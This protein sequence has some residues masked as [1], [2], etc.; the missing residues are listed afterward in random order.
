MPGTVSLFG[1]PKVEVEQRMIVVAARV[2]GRPCGRVAFDLENGSQNGIAYLVVQR[3]SRVP[4]LRH[5]WHG[6]L[7]R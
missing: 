3:A 5:P 4:G 2:G 1:K 6:P 7:L